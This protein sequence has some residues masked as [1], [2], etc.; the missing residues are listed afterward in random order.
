MDIHG[1]GPPLFALHSRE[2]LAAVVGHAQREHAALTLIPHAFGE[3]VR[4]RRVANIALGDAVNDRT[5]WPFRFC[6][7][8]SRGFLPLWP[9][10]LAR[11][12]RPRESVSRDSPLPQCHYPQYAAGQR[13]YSTRTTRIMTIMR[14]NNICLSSATHFEGGLFVKDVADIFSWA[15]GLL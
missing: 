10:R 4:G 6:A 15:P 8:V 9:G 11:H 13:C 12:I 14:A 7:L 1:I 2:Y 3:G 5:A